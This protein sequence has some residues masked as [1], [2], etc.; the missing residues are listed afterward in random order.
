MMCFRRWNGADTQ[1]AVV[2]V[3]T[4]PFLLLWQDYVVLVLEAIWVIPGFIGH[5][6]LEGTS[7]LCRRYAN[8]QRAWGNQLS[9]H[10]RSQRDLILKRT[11]SVVE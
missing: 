3:K 10:A 6:H 7:I 2:S 1:E 11:A 9:L 4:V 5:F 8:E